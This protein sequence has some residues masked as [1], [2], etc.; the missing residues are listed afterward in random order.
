MVCKAHNQF[1]SLF[2]KCKFDTLFCHTWWAEWAIIYLELSKPIYLP[3]PHIKIIKFQFVFFYEKYP[4]FIIFSPILSTVLK[5]SLVYLFT[6]FLLTHMPSHKL[7]S[8]KAKLLSTNMVSTCLFEEL[9]FHFQKVSV[10]TYL[11]SLITS[12]SVLIIM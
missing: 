10:S 5:I 4:L 8:I 12:W 11:Y 6:S 9:S 1:T 2:W 7:F 3:V